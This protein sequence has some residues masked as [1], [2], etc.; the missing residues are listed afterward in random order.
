MESEPD[1]PILV[2]G[3][4]PQ[5]RPKTLREAFDHLPQ[6]TRNEIMTYLR[7]ALM[8]SGLDQRRP[9]RATAYLVRIREI[10]SEN[11]HEVEEYT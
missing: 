3:S 7:H 6:E 9:A 8:W 4:P 2:G 10:L 5:H 1:T 11:G